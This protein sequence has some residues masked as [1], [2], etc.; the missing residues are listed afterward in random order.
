M[1]A[2]R[3]KR[4]RRAQAGA[5]LVEGVIVSGLLA[6]VL[7]CGLFFHRVY[8]AKFTTLRE[9]RV[10]AW[11]AALR[12]CGGG[13]AGALLSGLNGLTTLTQ[14]D[15][16]D[17]VDNPSRLSR[18]GRGVGDGAPVAVSAGPLLGSR[19]YTMRTRR[20]VACTDEAD[21]AAGDSFLAT[22]FHM[23]RDLA[24]MR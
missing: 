12:G 21:H 6:L 18:V 2:Q 16:D 8:S 22:S 14:S 24:S 4:S 10:E 5:A 19:R 11:V 13:L 17:L 1:A 3:R 7:A 20:E 9:A 23:I 15:E